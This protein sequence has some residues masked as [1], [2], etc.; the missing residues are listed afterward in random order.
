MRLH[1][2]KSK[3]MRAHGINPSAM[4]GGCLL[5]LAQMPIFMGLYYALQESVF[6]RLEPLT[7]W[8][9]PNLAAPDMLIRWGEDIPWISDPPSLGG[10]LYLGFTAAW[11]AQFLAEPHLA[12]M[13]LPDADRAQ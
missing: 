4:F 3:V 10:A 7:P 2:E 8:W 9:I 5:L 6:F 13:G 12:R 1:A 11:A